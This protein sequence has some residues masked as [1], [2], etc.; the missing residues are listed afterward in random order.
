MIFIIP[1]TLEKNEV[2]I[3]KDLVRLGDIMWPIRKLA[4]IF[5]L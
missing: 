4:S 3:R 2:F 1:K 5:S